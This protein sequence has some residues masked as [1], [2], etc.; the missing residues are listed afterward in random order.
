MNKTIC[1]FFASIILAFFV[2]A[3]ENST[4]PEDHSSTNVNTLDKKP[5]NPKI[6][7]YDLQGFETDA[8][9]RLTL[10]VSKD[11][12]TLFC[13]VIAYN[14]RP[15]EEYK[16]EPAEDFPE[17]PYLR[18]G[19]FK[20]STPVGIAN[21]GGKLQLNCSITNFLTNLQFDRLVLDN[22]YDIVIWTDKL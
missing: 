6:L 22:G 13:T 15:G 21:P 2:V 1:L 3:C 14:L 12:Q 18:I 10:R 9:G 8:Y 7:Q 5:V 19:G 16:L 17:L 11:E 20:P 4:A